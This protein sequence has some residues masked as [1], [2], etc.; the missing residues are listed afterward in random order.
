MTSKEQKNQM[1]DEFGGIRDRLQTQSKLIQ[2]AYENKN[3]QVLKL[4]VNESGEAL[5]KKLLGQ[6]NSFLQE[7][8]QPLIK[9][10]EM[11]LEMLALAAICTCFLKAISELLHLELENKEERN[12]IKSEVHSCAANTSQ[13]IHFTFG[14]KVSP[15]YIGNGVSRRAV[16]HVAR[17]FFEANPDSLI[18]F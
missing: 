10:K 7:H 2:K 8:E 15:R 4:L 11:G 12:W 6:Y 5:A 13:A 16:L 9:F 3:R 17:E 18:R 14:E 1:T